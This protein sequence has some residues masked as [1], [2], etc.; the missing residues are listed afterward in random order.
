ME[1]GGQMCLCE[2]IKVLSSQ[3]KQGSSA[4]IEMRE[5]VIGG[6]KKDEKL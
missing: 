1:R 3:R 6:L 2:G 4:V 5:V